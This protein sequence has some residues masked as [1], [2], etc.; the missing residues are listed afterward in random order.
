MPESS[1]KP[2]VLPALETPAGHGIA[3]CP[4]CGYC[5]RGAVSLVCPECGLNV[6]AARKSRRLREARRDS[7]YGALLALA[8]AAGGLHCGITGGWAVVLDNESVLKALFPIHL[9]LFN[10]PLR[11][12]IA[13]AACFFLLAGFKAIGRSLVVVNLIIALSGIGT[14]VVVTALGL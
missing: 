4:N 11:I 2:P 9:V 5:L 12:L 7:L 6:I 10:L 14:T 3:E 13:F 1:I 8:L